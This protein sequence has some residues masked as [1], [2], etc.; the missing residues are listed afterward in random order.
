ML[1]R[2]KH[3][4]PMHHHF[5][6][7]IINGNVDIKC[8]NTKEQIGDI[9]TKPLS[10]SAFNYLRHKLIGWWLLH[11]FYFCIYMHHTLCIS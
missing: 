10:S 5:R 3:I 4:S 2:I 6:Q 7:F 11:L 1:P 8:V 9:F